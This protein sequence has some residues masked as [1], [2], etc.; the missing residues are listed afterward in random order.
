M[1]LFVSFVSSL[2]RIA[3]FL[4]ELS[5]YVI[6]SSMVNRMRA[7]R[8]HRNNRRSHHALDAM[9]TSKC[10]Q[11]GAAH[12]S[13]AIC[14]NCGTYN[15]RKVLDVTAKVAKKAKAASK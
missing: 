1:R 7:T 10:Q 6:L 13:H 4:Q 9:R 14:M 15:G 5:E 12:R 3:P 2:I 8:S 11:C